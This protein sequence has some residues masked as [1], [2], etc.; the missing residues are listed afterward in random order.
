MHCVAV[1][2]L[3]GPSDRLREGA[4]LPTLMSSN[5]AREGPG[6]SGAGTVTGQGDAAANRSESET[7]THV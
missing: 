7:E 5:A 2:C 1:T 3:L 6:A 4:M